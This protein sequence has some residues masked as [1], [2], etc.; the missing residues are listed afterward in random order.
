MIQKKIGREVLGRKLREIR[1]SIG[2]LELQ[3]DRSFC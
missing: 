2:S 3:I 1:I